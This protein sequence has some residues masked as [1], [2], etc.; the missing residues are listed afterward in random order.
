MADPF[1]LNMPMELCLELMAIV[2]A[3][4]PE[5]VQLGYAVLTAKT[6]QHY[7]DLVLR[8]IM[9]AGGAAYVLQNPL[10]GRLRAWGVSFS[11]AF[12][13]QGNETKSLP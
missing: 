12:L 7:S 11:S 4:F 9:L 3:Y 10:D 5:A 6:V 8:R 13:P 2:G 1:I